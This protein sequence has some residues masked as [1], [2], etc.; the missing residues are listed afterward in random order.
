MFLLAEKEILDVCALFPGIFIS[1]ILSLIIRLF[2][3]KVKILLKHTQN[4]KYRLS[5][6]FDIFEEKN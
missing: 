2:A 1:K 3:E 4:P 6:I 5:E